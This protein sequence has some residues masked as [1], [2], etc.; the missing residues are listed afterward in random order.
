MVINFSPNK[1]CRMFVLNHILKLKKV[2][3][4][5]L[6]LTRLVTMISEHDIRCVIQQTVNIE[7][8]RLRPF[9]MKTLFRNNLHPVLLQKVGISIFDR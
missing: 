5:T 8:L 9:R 2:A 4:T 6:S 1:N 3:C 7:Y